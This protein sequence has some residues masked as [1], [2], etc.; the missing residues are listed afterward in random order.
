MKTEEEAQKEVKDLVMGGESGSSTEEKPKEESSPEV[1][2]DPEPAKPAEVPKDSPP[3]IPKETPPEPPKE[4]PKEPPAE[5]EPAKPEPGKNAEQLQEQVNNLNIALKKQREEGKA[6]S[7]SQKAELAE[8][9]A[10]LDRLKGA[11][12]PEPEEEPE[13]E[14]TKYMTPAQAEAFWAQKENE[15]A[16]KEEEQKRTSAIKS[17]IADLEKKWDGVDGKPKYDDS[18]VLEWQK[19]NEKLYLSP[20]EAF[21]AMNS[22]EMVDWEVKQRLAGK[23]PTEEVETPSPVPGEHEPKETL[24]QTEQETRAAIVEAIDNAEAEV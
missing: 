3:A 2:S 19:A 8:S 13:P 23:T 16:Q 21:N 1:K 17:E 12:N 20:N 6:E 22:K 5:L 18:K 14:E 4:E 10:L 7:E 11:F 24:P 9:K 15:R